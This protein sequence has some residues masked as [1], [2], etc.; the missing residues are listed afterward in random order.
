MVACD[1]ESALYRCLIGGRGRLSSSIKH[2]D[3]IAK[4][5]DRIDKLICSIVPTHV[6]GHQDW[7]GKQLTILEKIN[8]KMDDLAKRIASIAKRRRLLALLHTPSTSDGYPTVYIRGVPIVSEV[9]RTLKLSI[10]SNSL[11]QWWISKGRF[12]FQTEK[13]IDWK[14]LDAQQWLNPNLD[15]SFQNGFLTR[16]SSEQSWLV[17]TCNFIMDARVANVW[18]RQKSTFSNVPN[19]RLANYGFSK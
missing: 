7:K 1:G 10:A 3:I 14:C 15:V 16:L 9:E 8:V 4:C 11:K 18:P 17:G 19:H 13:E 5:H 12:T 6:R 2:C